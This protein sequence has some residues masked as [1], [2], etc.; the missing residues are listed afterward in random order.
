MTDFALES[1]AF[2]DHTLIP[3]RCARIASG[4]PVGP[5]HR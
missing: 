1:A 4:T 3:D 2:S 5:S